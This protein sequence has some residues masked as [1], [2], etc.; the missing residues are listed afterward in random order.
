MAAIYYITLCTLCYSI[1][2][3]IWTYTYT[4]IAIVTF[5]L[6]IPIHLNISWYKYKK[7]NLHVKLWPNQNLHN[8]IQFV[9]I[10]FESL[11]RRKSRLA[12]PTISVTSERLNEVVRYHG[13]DS[14]RAWGRAQGWIA[15][16]VV[17]QDVVYFREQ[18]IVQWEITE[19][20]GGVAKC[21][22]GGVRESDRWVHTAVH[23]RKIRICISRFTWINQVSAT[24]DI[25]HVLVW[26]EWAGRL[27]RKQSC[28]SHCWTERF[29]FSQGCGEAVLYNGGWRGLLSG[30]GWGQKD[31]LLPS[32]L[33]L[34]VPERVC[35]EHPAGQA[36]VRVSRL[37]VQL[38]QGEVEHGLPLKPV[39]GGRHFPRGSHLHHA[40]LFLLLQL[41]FQA[42]TQHVAC[43]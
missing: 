27:C 12:R 22:L 4:L 31:L 14:R 24:S 26:C 37:A 18:E 40:I 39:A 19:K 32:Q 25:W 10:Q 21:G 23:F 35:D 5:L 3:N 33:V 16:G 11:I 42:F 15:G 6:Y 30:N 28:Y 2:I 20:W 13:N 43:I 8:V 17:E 29:N 41:P 36:W 38:Q 1:K 9:Q 34:D 7:Y